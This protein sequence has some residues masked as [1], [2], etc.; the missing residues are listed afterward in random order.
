MRRLAAVC[1]VAAAAIAAIVPW[2]ETGVERW[3]SAG[4]YPILQ[5][6]ITW[7]S[8]RVPFALADIALVAAIAAWLLSAVTDLHHEG[9]HR[10]GPALLRIAGRTVVA[11]AAIYLVFLA[12]W[13][14]NY[15]RIPLERKLPFDAGAL[16][17]A[18]ARSAA[19][20]AV[21][22]VNALHAQAHATGW[23]AERPD[24]FVS[25]QGVF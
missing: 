4:A 7:L 25:C 13:G 23:P 18:A 17:A 14:L 12:L 16:N 15:R 8:N 5:Q 22:H 9:R 3:Y 6:P 19:L 10:I 1:I 21:S 24:R 20:V 11:V 2:P